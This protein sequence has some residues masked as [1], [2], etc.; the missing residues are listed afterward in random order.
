M[1][2]RLPT[3]KANIFL[4][5]CLHVSISELDVII[6]PAHINGRGLA[7]PQITLDTSLALRSYLSPGHGSREAACKLHQ[8]KVKFCGKLILKSSQDQWELF[9]KVVCLQYI[10]YR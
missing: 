1:R 6:N 9:Q 10:S 4:R 8:D 3:V 5:A 7:R 2:S